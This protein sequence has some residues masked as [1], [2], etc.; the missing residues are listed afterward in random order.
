MTSQERRAERVHG[1]PDG[2]HRRFFC[3]LFLFFRDGLRGASLPF[4][5]SGNFQT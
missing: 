3:G 2:R 1:I 4:A 5:K